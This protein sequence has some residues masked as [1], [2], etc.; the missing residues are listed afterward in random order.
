MQLI[1]LAI[2]I[3]PHFFY[4][5]HNLRVC[6]PDCSHVMPA[7]QTMD[8]TF[9]AYWWTQTVK[10][11]VVYFFIWVFTALITFGSQVTAHGFIAWVH[12]VLI[13]S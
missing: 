2:Q 7:M 1:Y 10:A 13:A 4:L 3:Q 9:G 12:C 5:S 8:Y 6:L 11:E